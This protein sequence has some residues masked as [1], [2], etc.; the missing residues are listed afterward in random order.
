MTYDE[1]MSLDETGK[2]RQKN[3]SNEVDSKDTPTMN[4]NISDALSGIKY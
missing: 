3:A 4:K 1:F 2:N